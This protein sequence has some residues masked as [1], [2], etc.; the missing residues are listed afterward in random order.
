[1]VVLNSM[2]ALI[3][4]GNSPRNWNTWE[5][6]SASST[7]CCYHIALNGENIFNSDAIFTTYEG[8]A[9]LKM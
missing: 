5:S 6:G 7:E 8:A 3:M 4:N 2:I 9:A 1:M